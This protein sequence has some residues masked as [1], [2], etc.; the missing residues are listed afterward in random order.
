[1]IDG[2]RY[3]HNAFGYPKDKGSSNYCFKEI[4]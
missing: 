1:V 3:V 2:V 4:R